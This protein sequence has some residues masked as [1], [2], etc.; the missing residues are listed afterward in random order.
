MTHFCA[1]FVV[2]KELYTA[3]IGMHKNFFSPLHFEKN[4]R[5]DF[6][7]VTDSHMKVPPDHYNALHATSKGQ[8][9]L[10]ILVVAMGKCNES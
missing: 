3:V 4:W 8:T 2:G 10:L 7:Q 5:M 9:P 1:S 6:F